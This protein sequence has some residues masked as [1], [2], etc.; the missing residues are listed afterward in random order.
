MQQYLLHK[1]FMHT[2][3]ATVFTSSH[4]ESERIGHLAREDAVFTAQTLSFLSTYMQ[5][6][7]G[8]VFIQLCIFCLLCLVFLNFND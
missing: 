3:N 8:S 1:Y 6:F 2:L 4:D 5:I 7:S